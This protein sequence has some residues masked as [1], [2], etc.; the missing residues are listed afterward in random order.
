MYLFRVK[1]LKR[2]KDIEFWQNEVIQF[3]TKIELLGNSIL[4]PKSKK[5]GLCQAKGGRGAGGPGVLREVSA[6][7]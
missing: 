6:S 2:A 5:E 4:A 3:W 1:S 7:V